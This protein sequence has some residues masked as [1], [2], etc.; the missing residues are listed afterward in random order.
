[1]KVIILMLSLLF[2]TT[3]FA[4]TGNRK[5]ICKNDTGTLLAYVDVFYSLADQ[6]TEVFLFERNLD[7]E[8][9]DQRVKYEE[10]ASV[11]TVEFKSPSGLSISVEVKQE[12]CEIVEK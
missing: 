4:G 6:Y 2:A 7:T 5:L 10:S 8:L 1:M 12:S 9:F 3:S 11:E